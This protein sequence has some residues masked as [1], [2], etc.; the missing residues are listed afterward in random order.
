MDP[1]WWPT[2]ILALPLLQQLNDWV[3]KRNEKRLPKW[4]FSFAPDFAMQIRP[5][6]T[7]A[8]D[9]LFE[10]VALQTEGVTAA[11]FTEPK[12][13]RGRTYFRVRF[14]LQVVGGVWTFK[15]RGQ[16]WAPGGPGTREEYYQVRQRVTDA[17]KPEHFSYLQ[18]K[19]MLAPHCLCCG[20]RLTDP[21]SMARWI[22]PECFGS[23]ST[24][25]PHIFKAMA[26]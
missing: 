2:N 10:C 6:I 12:Q 5:R 13:L 3:I 7:R 4:K 24:N 18:P 21:V 11:L 8:Y 19:M 16:A 23:A 1:V 15:Y 22:G 20:K 9:M 26:A 25:L 14:D 17:L